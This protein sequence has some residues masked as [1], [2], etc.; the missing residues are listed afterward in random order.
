MNNNINNPQ[1]NGNED[2]NKKTI[3]N[4]GGFEEKT[5][6]AAFKE[7][8][9][10]KQSENSTDCETTEKNSIELE[11]A[12]DKIR[13]LEE[14][15][16]DVKDKMLREAAE[17]ENIRR[18][19]QKEREDAKKFSIASFAKD[20]LDV[21][22]NFSRAL[23]AAPKNRDELDDHMKSLLEGI[24]ATQRAMIK[25]FEKNG[26]KEISSIDEKFDPNLHEVMFEVPTPDKEDGTIIQILE[27]GYTLNDRLLRPAR[28][29][30]SKNSD[31]PDGE[32]VIDQEV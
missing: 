15:L 25:I 14:E 3:E 23:E 17:V 10:N 4:I 19:S 22:D 8:V 5:G 32:H 11:R 30:V 1:K 21:S 27:T 28:V 29:G 18:R 26:I 13:R 6:P 9:E 31:K 7:K 16:S 12:L 20:L 2:N 24:E